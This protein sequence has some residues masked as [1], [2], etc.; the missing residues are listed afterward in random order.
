MITIKGLIMFSTVKSKIILAIL[1]L[2]ILG[3]VVSS[4]YLSSTLQQLSNRSEKHS[5]EMLSKS[6]FQTMTISMMMGDPDIVQKAFKD[7]RTIEG[8]EKLKIIKSKA[9][10]AVYAPEEKFTKDDLILNIFRTKKTKVIEKKIN[11]HHTL[12]LIKPM[13]AE[14]RCLQCHYNAK[15]GYTLGVMDLFVSLDKNDATISKTNMTLIISLI[16]AAILF[17]VMAYIFFTKEIFNPLT[18]LKNKIAALV[19]GDKDLTKRLEHKKGNEFGDTATEVNNFIEM[20]Q[21]TINEVKSLGKQNKNIASEIEIASHVICEGTQQEQ[22]L[23]EKTSK[24]SEDIKIILNEAIQTATTTQETIILA[25]KALVVAQE[26]LLT[27]NNKVEDF[28]TSEN[29]LADELLSLKSDANQVKE[30]L[31]IIKD[32]AEQTNL[33]ALNAAIEA[34][35][36]GEHGRGFAVVADEVRKLA[37]RTQKSLTEIDISVSTIVQ[38]INDVSEKMVQNTQNVEVLSEIANSVNSEISTTSNSMKVS[39]EASNKTKEDSEKMSESIREIISNIDNIEAL[40]TANETSAFSIE[41]DLVHLVSVASSLQKTID[42]FK[43]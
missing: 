19:S 21:Y 16:L 40:S 10:I 4:F 17:A 43:S 33:L 15:V 22:K 32:I 30:V 13:I 7:I 36:A 3:L 2:S 41:K 28:V 26:S 11:G 27:L 31:N 24:K 42:E 39:T 5:L 25:D 20:I 8:I 18:A 38:S 1:S 35:R 37:E 23:V 9:V 34:A 6:I 12:R 29:E 14:K